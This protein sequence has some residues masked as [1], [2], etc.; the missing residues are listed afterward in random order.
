MNAV[1][2]GAILLGYWA[3]GLCF[4]RFWRST[5]D[6]LFRLFAF[7]FWLLAAERVLLIVADFQHEVRPWVYITRLIAFLCIIFAILDKNWKGRR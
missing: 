2:S 5:N 1:I 3:I 4:S 6:R 7:A